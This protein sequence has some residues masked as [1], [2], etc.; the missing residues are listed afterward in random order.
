MGPPPDEPTDELEYLCVDGFLRTV[1]GA[2]ALKTAF[3]L[4]LIDHLARTP[5]IPL[6]D[7]TASFSGDARGLRF[8]VTLLVAHGVL[9]DRRGTITLGAEFRRAL[10]YR[11]L[12]EMKLDYGA[13]VLPDF[14]ERFTAAIG[15]PDAFARQART[16]KLFCYDR[17][18]GAGPDDYERTKRWMRITTCLTRYEARVALR[19]HDFG[20]HERIL[21]IGGNSGEF[22]LQVC[23]RHPAVSASVF[24]LPMVC[25]IG[26]EHVR[27][28]AEAD[29]ITFVEGSAL[30]DPLPGG[31]DLVTFKSMLHDWPDAEA[32]RFVTRASEALKPGGTLLI[33]ERGPVEVADLSYASIPFLLFFRS[34]RPPALYTEQLAALGFRD[35]Q[36]QWIGLETPFFLVTGRK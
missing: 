35:V 21:D 11:D 14:T 36:T 5:A 9:E 19:H 7:L 18:Q 15:S 2:R 22:M 32:R 24:D 29:R 6:A 12:L 25:R 17:A 10:R 8:L 27:P 13:L 34:F 30:S 33:F 23:R 20:R 4:N 3:E 28:H 31:Q 16:F 1:I 26:R